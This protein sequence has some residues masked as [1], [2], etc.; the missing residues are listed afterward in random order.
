MRE[1]DEERPPE[2]GYRIQRVPRHGAG[3]DLAWLSG[4]PHRA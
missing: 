4:R 1:K 3:D 2:L